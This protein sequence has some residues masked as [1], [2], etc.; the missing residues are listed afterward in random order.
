MCIYLENCSK[1]QSIHDDDE[2]RRFYDD[3]DEY[4]FLPFS[5][6]DDAVA[7]DFNDDSQRPKEQSVC[8]FVV[9]ICRDCELL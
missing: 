6:D 8:W 7:D 2:Y 5:D 1:F 4:C 3:D 9:L